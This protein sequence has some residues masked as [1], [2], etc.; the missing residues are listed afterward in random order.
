MK[1]TSKTKR[2]ASAESIARLA[3]NGQDISSY[4]T[5][6]GKMMPPLNNMDLDLNEEMIE[7]LN[8]AARRLNVSRKTLIERFIWRGLDQHSL[9]QKTRKAG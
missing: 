1:K 4:F 2:P 5:N 8:E 6:K 3:D 7:E 9:A